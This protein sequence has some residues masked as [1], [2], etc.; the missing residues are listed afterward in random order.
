MT[1]AVRKMT[2]RDYEAVGHALA[3][4]PFPIIIPCHRAIRSDGSLGGYQGGLAMKRSLLER[5][6]IRFDGGDASKTRLVA[7]SRAH[8]RRC[9][10]SSLR[11]DKS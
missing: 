3:A 2:M 7:G 1:Y 8:G 11:A 6:G 5:E 4:N 9:G 10:V